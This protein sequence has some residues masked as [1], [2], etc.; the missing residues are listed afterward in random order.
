[1]DGPRFVLVVTQEVG[2]YDAIRDA[3]ATRGLALIRIEAARH[4]VEDLFRDE[5]DQ[6]GVHGT[7]A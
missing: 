3:A 2:P 1:V 5:S 6:D 4:R 7:A